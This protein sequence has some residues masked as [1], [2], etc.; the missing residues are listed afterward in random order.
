VY[1]LYGTQDAAPPIAIASWLAP[2]NQIVMFFPSR[3]LVES[4]AGVALEFFRSRFEMPKPKGRSKNNRQLPGLFAPMK[5][6]LPM[7]PYLCLW[8]LWC[9]NNDDNLFAVGSTRSARHL[10]LAVALLFPHI[11][12]THLR[13]RVSATPPLIRDVLVV[14]FAGFV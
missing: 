3:R 1:C 11:P 7:P 10:R 13:R 14:I 5:R 4:I 2:C 8:P 12:H 9:S 6:H